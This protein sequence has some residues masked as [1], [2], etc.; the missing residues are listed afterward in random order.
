MKTFTHNAGR[1][2]TVAVTVNAVKRV[3][4]LLGENLL[5][6]AQ[7]V[8]RLLS[9]PI[10]LCDVVYCVC[11]PEADAQQVSDEEFGQAMF[12]PAIAGAKQALMEELVDFFPEPADREALKAAIQSGNTMSRRAAELLKKKLGSPKYQAAI[13][14]ALGKVEMEIDE[15]LNAVGN[16]SGNSPALSVLTPEE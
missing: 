14:A 16:S 4:D 15:A 12:G 2:W 10:L 6:T 13:E 8:P 7:V 3:R 9:D 1:T 5:D 11:K